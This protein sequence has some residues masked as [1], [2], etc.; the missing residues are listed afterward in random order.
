[1]KLTTLLRISEWISHSP[2]VN[3]NPDDRLRPVPG[4]PNDNN[5]NFDDHTWD[6]GVSD[7]D[8]IVEG[9]DW[10]LHI[11]A[12]DWEKRESI[13]E[14][15]VYEDENPHKFWIKIK[16]HGLRK[17]TD[18]NESFKERIRKHTKKIAKSWANEAKKMHNNPE[19]NEVGNPIQ[20]TWKQCFREA[21]KSP[22]I[23]GYVK[24]CG[25]KNMSTSIADPV[26]FTPR[27]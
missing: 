16:T 6:T 19:L 22:K 12:N 8:S 23:T 1:M 4:G 27:K 10:F 14:V 2:T 25:E 5:P 7:W 13:A 17:P 21:L 24:D 9:K 26:N 20:P 15:V 11:G 18:T 3:A